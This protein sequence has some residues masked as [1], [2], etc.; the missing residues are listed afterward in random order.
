M[1]VDIRFSYSEILH[2]KE[3]IMTSKSVIAAITLYEKL[4]DRPW[5]FQFFCEIEFKKNCL[6]LH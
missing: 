4:L 1:L 3:K 2:F 5:F 6:M